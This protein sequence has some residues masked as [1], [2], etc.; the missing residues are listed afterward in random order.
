MAIEATKISD[1]V[2][3]ILEFMKTSDIPMAEQITILRSTA[4]L[5]NQIIL[6]EVTAANLV[7]TFNKIQERI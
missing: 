1:G 3:D 7:A 6:S 4:E 5:L 2:R